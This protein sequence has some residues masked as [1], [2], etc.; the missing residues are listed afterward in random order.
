MFQR[1]TFPLT[2]AMAPKRKLA[3]AAAAPKAAKAAKAKVAVPPPEDVAAGRADL[4][5]EHW[6]VF[7]L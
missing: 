2:E 7:R 1:A 3:V 5:V 4:T 6:C